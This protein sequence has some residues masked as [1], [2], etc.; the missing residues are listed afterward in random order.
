MEDD[1]RLPFN[2]FVGIRHKR[3]KTRLWCLQN[4]RENWICKVHSESLLLW[5]KSLLPNNTL[6]LF[7]PMSHENIMIVRQTSWSYSL[8]W[9]PPAIQKKEVCCVLNTIAGYENKEID[10]FENTWFCAKWICISVNVIADCDSVEMQIQVIT[11]K[12]INSI[13][14]WCHESKTI[15][16]CQWNISFSN[17]SQFHSPPYIYI[18]Y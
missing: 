2:H 11:M 6:V 14:S 1:L 5:R 9:K 15:L 16:S 18:Y 12:L 10:D 17:L 4:R 8:D 13:I 7:H 3:N